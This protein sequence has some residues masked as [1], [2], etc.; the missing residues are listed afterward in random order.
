MSLG[1][2]IL[3]TIGKKWKYFSHTLLETGNRKKC[4]LKNFI[5]GRHSGWT[6]RLNSLI[7]CATRKFYKCDCSD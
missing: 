6:C 3:I 4:S 2:N 5:F 7:V 1:V